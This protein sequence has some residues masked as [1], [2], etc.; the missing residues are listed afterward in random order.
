M[1]FGQY[2]SQKSASFTTIIHRNF[3]TSELKMGYF[4]THVCGNFTQKKQIIAGSEPF[5]ILQFWLK[6]WWFSLTVKKYSL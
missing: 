4:S 2:S 6:C 3:I 1:V 5:Q